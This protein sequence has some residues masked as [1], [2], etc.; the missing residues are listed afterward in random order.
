MAEQLDVMAVSSDLTFVTNE[1]GKKLLDRFGV[2]LTDDTRF[3]GCLVG[4]FFISGFYKL[5]P[6]LEKVEKIRILV[7]LNTDRTA[8]ELLQIAAEQQEL[9]FK[10]HAEAKQQVS[11]EVLREL[12]KSQDTS[13][14][15]I[16]VMKFVEWVR[17]GKLE[18]RA[19][20]SHDLHAKVYIMT[21]AE[22]DRDKGRVITGSSNL[23]QSGLAENLEFNVELK[24]RSDYDFAIAKFNELWDIAVEVTKPYEETIVTRSPYAE[25]SPYE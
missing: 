4:Y 2:L 19:H 24:N 21:F 12:E 18:I 17:S 10:S 3:F 6:A 13:E 15:E 11:N 8:Y 23:T 7:G 20:P 22:G 9:V 14:I 16:G 25:F 1:P 5:Y